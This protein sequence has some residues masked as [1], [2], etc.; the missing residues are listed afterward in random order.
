MKVVSIDALSQALMDVGYFADRRL[1][2]AVFLALKL[3]RPLLLE[4]EPGVG[5]TE[6][7]KS[8]ATALSRAMIRL[9]CYDGMEQREALYEWNYSAQLLH[10]RASSAANSALNSAPNSGHDVEQ[11]LYQRKYY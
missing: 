7:A 3:E 9:Q 8:L 1:S 5:K 6:L 4:G 2:T 10:L 11:D